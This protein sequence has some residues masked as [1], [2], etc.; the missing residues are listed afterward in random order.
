M[1][2]ESEFLILRKI[3][4]FQNNWG[5]IYDLFIFHVIIMVAFNK[6]NP[7]VKKN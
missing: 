1:Y 2:I 6:G 5:I 7:W 4:G 3:N